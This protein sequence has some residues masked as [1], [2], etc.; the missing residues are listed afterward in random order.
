MKIIR[1][2][3]LEKFAVQ[4]VNSGKSLATWRK[5]VEEANWKNKQDVLRDFPNA[6]MLPNKRARFEISHNTFRLISEL[7]Y[8][9]GLLAIR[10]VGTHSEYD[11]IDATTI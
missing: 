11:K 2:L 4:H 8:D 3:I 9:D 1:P 7:D 5:A 10:F 6:K